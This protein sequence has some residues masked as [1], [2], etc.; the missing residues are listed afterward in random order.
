MRMIHRVDRAARVAPGNAAIVWW[1]GCTREEMGDRRGARADFAH[2]RQF[3]FEV[4]D[5]DAPCGV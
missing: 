5:K 4:L 3:G 2:G 1:R